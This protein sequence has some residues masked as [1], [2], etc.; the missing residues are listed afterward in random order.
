MDKIYI[1]TCKRVDKQ[2]TYNQ[3]SPKQK[4]KVVFVVQDWERDQYQ[5]DADYLILPK[6]INVSDQFAIAKTRQYIYEYA[7]DQR[8]ALLDDDLQF[9]RRNMKYWTGSSDMDKSARLC[10]HADMDEMFDLYTEWLSESGIAFCGCALKNNPPSSKI[11]T[12]NSSMAAAY[13]I[14]GPKI[15]DVVMQN[16]FAQLSVSEDVHFILTL[17]ANGKR[18]RICSYFV[19]GTNDRAPS[20]L[21]NTVKQSEVTRCHQFL[22]NEFPNIYQMRYDPDNPSG[23]Y[24]GTGKTRIRWSQSF[25]TKIKGNLDVFF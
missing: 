6:T 1:M 21:W 10:T 19:V 9:Y 18:N 4:S 22:V 24:K 7:K 20:V 3:L 23:G 16:N 5:Y 25:N 8:Y 14:D 2:V 15:R 12:E 11:R 17:L 13:W